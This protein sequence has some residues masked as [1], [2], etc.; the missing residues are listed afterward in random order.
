M[1]RGA[2][3]TLKHVHT[4]KDRH[5][6]ARSYF[7][8]PGVKGTPLPG[9]P[10]SLAFMAAYNAAVAAYVPP[11]GE[12]K[13]AGKP[14]SMKALCESYWSSTPFKAK[15]E[16]T[17]YV[18]RRQLDRFLVEHGAKDCRTVHTMHLDSI[19]AK[20]TDRPAAAMDLRKRLSRVFR[21]A[22]KLGWRRDNP[23]AATDTMK[24]GTH[25]T[26]TEA[27]IEQ[28]QAHWKRGTKQRTALDLLLYTGQRS[29]DVRV[30]MWSA[31]R[32]GRFHVEA[33]D[34]T[35]QI[36]TAPVHS[37]LTKTLAAHPRSHMVILATEHG[38]P[39][40]EKGFGNFMARLIDK[41]GL[42]DRCVAHGLRKAAARR[43]A[44]S[45]ATDAEIMAITGHRTRKEV[46]R[47]TEAANRAN[48]A[49]SGMAKIESV[50]KRPA[51]PVANQRAKRA[52]S[53]G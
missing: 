25:H 53:N 14:Y 42:P 15:K 24:P 49:D 9:L 20:M 33:Q 43:L 16:R 8:P 34:K 19:F 23:I 31:I 11:G 41:A 35:G 17:R 46:T 30:M 27:E 50:N 47:Y 26:W 45:G 40:S 51:N 10:G 22:V 37:E 29:G 48:S 7:R 28:A 5:G 4:F 21:H 12:A 1:G 52:K 38:E 36:V 44:E 13:P 6:K 2:T 32:N 39:F 18:E 3:V